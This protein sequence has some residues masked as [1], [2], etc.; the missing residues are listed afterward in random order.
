M[1]DSTDCFLGRAV[2]DF[3]DGGE[4]T[5]AVRMGDIIR[6]VEIDN[7]EWWGGHLYTDSQENTGWFPGRVL[8]CP[9]EQ[10]NTGYHSL[11]SPALPDT[12]IGYHSLWFEYRLVSR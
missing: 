2:R 7:S 11:C 5:L 10:E 4:N 8:K 12:S 9:E 6:V 3:N 1:A